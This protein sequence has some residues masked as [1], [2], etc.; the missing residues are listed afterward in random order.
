MSFAEFMGQYWWI[1][2]IAVAVIVGVIL[3]LTGHKKKVQEWV[4]FIV[5]EVERQLGGGTGELKLRA[6]YD[7]FLTRFPKMSTFISFNAFSKMVDSALET[8]NYWIIKNEGV[9]QYMGV[10]PPPP[11]STNPIGFTDN[12]SEEQ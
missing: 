2:F 10:L 5:A 1:F 9:A 12:T 8:L 3:I 4:K 7:A 11:E 6:A